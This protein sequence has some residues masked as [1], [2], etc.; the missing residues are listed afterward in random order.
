MVGPGCK[1]Y[2][3][4]AGQCVLTLRICAGHRSAGCIIGGAHKLLLSEK[5]AGQGKE[6]ES[7]FWRFGFRSVVAWYIGLRSSDVQA[8][9]HYD[10]A[11]AI[12]IHFI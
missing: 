8:P 7:H 2:A 1:S 6:S 10:K 5:L 9:D 11:N 4:E 12:A 3:Q